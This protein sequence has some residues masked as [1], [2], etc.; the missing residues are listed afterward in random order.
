MTRSVK[1]WAG[2]AL[3]AYGAVVIALTMLKAFFVIGMLWRP[4]A[5]RGRSVEW[6]PFAQARAAESWFGPLFDALGNLALFVP[7]GALL[8]ILLENRARAILVVVACGTVTSISVEVLQY[9]F[10]LGNSDVTDLL[11]N[12]TGTLMGAL[13]ARICGRRLHPVW[14]GLAL[15]AAVVFAILV[16]LGPRLGDPEN[17]VELSGSVQLAAADAPPECP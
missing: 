14:T 10:A 6:A 2:L 11:F 7:L 4:E 5:Q 9:A 13:I 1:A 12:S 15:A 17:V 8:F 3:L 16:A